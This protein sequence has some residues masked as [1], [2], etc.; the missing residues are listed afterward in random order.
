MKEQKRIEKGLLER[1]SQIKKVKDERAEVKG[2]KRQDMAENKAEFFLH[3][4][5]G[6]K[7]HFYCLIRTQTGV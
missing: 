2:I 3:F 1:K 4:I 6:M 7:L 5:K